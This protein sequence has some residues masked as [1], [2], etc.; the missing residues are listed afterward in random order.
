MAAPIRLQ[1]R[2]PTSDLSSDLRPTPTQPP[3]R[4][5]T[6][7]ST[8][9]GTPTGT[10]TGTLTSLLRHHTICRQDDLSSDLR[11]PG[12]PGPPGPLGPPT[13][14][15]PPAIHDTPDARHNS[16]SD[17]KEARKLRSFCSNLKNPTKQSKLES[18]DAKEQFRCETCK[19]SK[20]GSS[21]SDWKQTWKRS[22]FGA[23][24]ASTKQTWLV[25]LIGSRDE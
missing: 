6:P 2:P 10:S 24:L 23:K 20:V 5:G 25:V 12:P 8:P 3:N 16:R 13:S 15:P 19:Q 4:R 17:K 9:T 7:T 21:S 14:A 18:R 11:P 1:L 22:S